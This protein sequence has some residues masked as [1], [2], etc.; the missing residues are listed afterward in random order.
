MIEKYLKKKIERYDIISFDIFDTLIERDVRVP[1]DIFKRIAESCFNTENE[2]NAFWKN[3]VWAEQEARKNRTDGEV[4]LDE[5]Y[6]K[7]LDKY[8]DSITE[9]LMQSEIREEIKACRPKNKLIS[10]YK[11]AMQRGKKV[12]FISDMYLPKEVISELL[13]K[14]SVYEYEKLYV[15]NAYRANKV[16]GE[17]FQIVCTE[18]QLKKEDWLHIGD[19]FKADFKG[20]RKSGISSILLYR[21]GLIKNRLCKFFKG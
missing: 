19:S 17:L 20:A 15:S 1:T 8:D 21:K 14:C 3:R 11:H 7:L 10:V 2:R 18:N 16:S 4:T 13:S 5:I 9:K 6:T 12:Y